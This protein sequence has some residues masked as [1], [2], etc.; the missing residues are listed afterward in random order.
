MLLNVSYKNFK[1]TERINNEVGKPFN[2]WDRLRL[3]GTGSPRLLITSASLHIRNLLLLDNSPNNCNIELRPKGIIIRFRSLLETYALIIPYYKLSLYKGNST[4][5][6][7]HRDHYFIKVESK[8]NE[9]HEFMRK[10][11]KK[12]SDSS[13]H[14]F[15][16]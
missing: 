5:Y 12:R 6:S 10:I 8:T 7:I 1:V 13:S 2:L 14:L 3:K 16:S 9:I 11:L 4:E 15:D